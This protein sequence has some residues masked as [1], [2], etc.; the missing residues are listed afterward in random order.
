[1]MDEVGGNYSLK[2]G[3]HVPVFPWPGQTL[4]HTSKKI[5]F[6]LKKEHTENRARIT[7]NTVGYQQ[8]VP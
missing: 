5:W 6:Q 7:H 4:D 1:M 3:L 2:G 8:E